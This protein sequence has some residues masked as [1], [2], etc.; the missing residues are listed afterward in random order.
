MKLEDVSL[1]LANSVEAIDRILVASRE[2]YG[3]LLPVDRQRVAKYIVGCNH[4]NVKIERVQFH[5]SFYCNR[6]WPDPTKYMPDREYIWSIQIVL[7]TKKKKVH[8]VSLHYPYDAATNSCL[9]VQDLQ[10]LRQQRAADWV[11][12]CASPRQP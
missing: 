4:H 11:R 6:I 12:K 9:P 2:L 8:L 1:R 5:E 7:M 10:L 3:K